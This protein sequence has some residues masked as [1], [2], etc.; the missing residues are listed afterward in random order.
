MFNQIC[1][2]ELMPFLA[3]LKKSSYYFFTATLAQ[4]S[5]SVPPAPHTQKKFI[6][7]F[8]GTFSQILWILVGH[9]NH[10]SNLS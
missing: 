10:V 3:I 1:R 5:N 2:M 4:K 9:R 7:Y 8:G 6:Q